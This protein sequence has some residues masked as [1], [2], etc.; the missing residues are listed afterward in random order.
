MNIII[1]TQNSCVFCDAAK[2]QFKKRNWEY[3]EYNLSDDENKVS[4]FE[5]FPNAKTV[6]QIWIDDEHIGGYDELMAHLKGTKFIYG[7]SWG[8]NIA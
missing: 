1:Y 8:Q 2:H 6:P 4:L 3:T 7:E 5:R